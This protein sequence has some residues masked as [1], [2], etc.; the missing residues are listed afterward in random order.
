M[1]T[2]ILLLFTLLLLA[3]GYAA[4]LTTT[5][6]VT[7]Q[8]ITIPA[9]GYTVSFGVYWYGDDN[10][11]TSAAGRIELRD[12][13]GTLL[14]LV[15]ASHYQTTGVSTSASLGSLTDVSSSVSIYAADG[16][17]ADGQ[18]TAQWRITGVPPGTYVLRFFEYSTWANWLQNT[19]VWTETSFL[20]GSVAGSAPTIAWSAAP[21]GAASGA[22]YTVSAQGHDVDG[23][24]TEV[25]VW[26]NGQPFAFAGGGNGTDGSSGNT[27]SDTGSQTVIFTA[28]A[29]DADGT[30]SPLISHTVNIGAPVNA[31]PA[32]TLLSPGVQTVTTGT[33]LSISARATDADGNL[34]AHNLDIQR[35]AGDWNFQGG[36]AAGEPFQGGPVGSPSDSTRTA[37]FTF[38]DVGTYYVRSAAN[39]GSGWSQ[40][41]TVAITV[42]APPPVQYALTTSAAAGGSVTPGGLFNS[43]TN[44]LVTATP[45]AT[46]NFTGWTGDA[47][48]TANLLTVLMDRN[49]AVQATFALK[50]YTLTTS[51]TAGGAVTPGGVFTTGTNV[52]V[53]AI[54]DAVHDFVGWTGDAGGAA[55]PLT[56]LMDRSKTVQAMFAPKNYSLSTSAGTGGSVSPGGLF[57]AGTNATVTAVPDATHDFVGWTGD[58]GGTS[59]PLVIPMDRSKSVQANFVPRNY[60]LVTSATVG[61]AVTPGGTYPPGTTITISATPDAMH[62]FLGWAG[63]AGGTVL[64]VAILLDAPKNVQAV[65][66]DKTS[67]TLTFPAPADQ[68][69][70]ASLLTLNATVSSGL[71]V[72]YAVLSGPATLSGNQL[73]ITGPG[74]VTVQASQAGDGYYLPAASITR[75]FNAYAAAVLRY[76]PNGRTLLQGRLANGAAPFV[77]ETP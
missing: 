17:P 9:G 37:S 42:V 1:K 34:T 76:R 51:A 77:V 25:K 31:P 44:A 26:K 61:G 40:S 54:P 64:T 32:V 47:T 6:V 4:P 60:P 10:P 20:E 73:V 48:G 65:F 18:L 7:T 24:L 27:T 29:V 23:N 57:N 28:Q 14:G 53:T 33:T 70:A 72:S 15:T 74:A 38:A 55:N 43:G 39:D 50:S 71:P 16:S 5:F 45:D 46:H 68:P 66:T 52:T 69:V 36:F 22:P 56:V 63:D 41:T 11:L 62:R 59:N 75:T 2:R 30:A 49:K 12:S 58:A 35:P 19:R 3:T 21:A 8:T 13:G 67:Q